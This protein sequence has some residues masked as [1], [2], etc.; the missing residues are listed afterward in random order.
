MAKVNQKNLVLN[1]EEA[2]LL[3]EGKEYEIIPNDKGIFLLIDKTKLGKNEGKQVC[4]QVPQNQS[5]DKQSIGQ[6]KQKSIGEKGSKNVSQLEEEKQQV[7]GLIKKSKLGDLVEGKFEGTLNEKQKKAL[8]ELVSTSKVFVFKLNDT[9]KKGVYKVKEEGFS[10]APREKKESEDFNAIEKDYK[11][12]TLETDGFLVIRGSSEASNASYA[13]EKKIKEGLLKGIK[14]FDGNYYLIETDLLNAYIHK[15]ILLMQNKSS[16]TL[17]ELARSLN[18]SKRLTKI[19]CEF[20][21]DEG[22]LMEKKKE[23][24]NY[25]K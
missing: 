12:Y 21:K 15:L 17:E 6:E 22:E 11:N 23:Q 19:I 7:I 1:N 13:F 4:V 5:G 8:L 20:L 24:Y 10:D 25:I 18:A 3:S 16:Q 9:Y 14:S 2:S